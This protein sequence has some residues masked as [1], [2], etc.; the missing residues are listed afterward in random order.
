MARAFVCGCLGTSMSPDERAFLR[1]AD[2]LGVI[3]FKRNI[4]GSAEVYA[5]TEEIRA[6]LGRDDVVVL[7]DQEGG[8]VQRLGP[9][10]WRRY[11]PIPISISGSRSSGSW[12]D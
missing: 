2:P 8:R 3:L 9:P 10:L 5:L 1:E 12:R 11:P 7:V 6:T 4:G